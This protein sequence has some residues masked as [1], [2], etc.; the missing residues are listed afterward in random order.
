MLSANS[1]ELNLHRLPPIS[2]FS[3]N[4]CKKRHLKVL[5][6]LQLSLV[7]QSS[8]RLVCQG[9]EWF[10]VLCFVGVLLKHAADKQTSKVGTYF[11][12]SHKYSSFSSCDFC[13]LDSQ[14]NAMKGGGR[15]C[16]FVTILSYTDSFKAK[17]IQKV[18]EQWINIGLHWS[19]QEYHDSFYVINV[20]EHVQEVQF[21]TLSNCCLWAVWM[22][23]MNDFGLY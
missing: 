5:A 9:T 18:S 8:L 23:H 10:C 13:I 11:W 3:V 21:S 20:G 16:S 7:L 1:C 14:H 2:P 12:R 19:L 22:E 17:Y 15:T 4:S 6:S